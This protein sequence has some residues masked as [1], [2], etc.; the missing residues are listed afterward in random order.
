MI[1]LASTGQAYAAS[2]NYLKI[3][4]T[5]SAGT[6]SLSPS[7]GSGTYGMNMQCSIPGLPASS[8][9]TNQNGG[10]PVSTFPT[11]TD[12]STTGNNSFQLSIISTPPPAG[13]LLHL[14][15]MMQ[16]ATPFSGD[17]YVAGVPS[18]ITIKSL[19]DDTNQTITSGGAAITLTGGVVGS[20]W[21][22]PALLLPDKSLIAMSPS[23]AIVP[24][25]NW[26]S[27]SGGN[28]ISPGQWM[29]PP[30]Q[31]TYATQACTSGGGWMWYRREASVSNKPIT[32]TPY[33]VTGQQT[34]GG[35]LYGL[36]VSGVAGYLTGLKYGI[37]SSGGVNLAGMVS[38]VMGY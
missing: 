17:Y 36:T 14:Y 26:F 15:D 5:P 28:G 11:A 29:G 10:N 2:I 24:A 21:V 32:L 8:F 18:T 3:T 27:D 22:T 12:V 1:G 35:N 4:A 6:Y 7:P 34:S 9:W 25:L 31:N 30:Y 13:R 23:L 16:I 20:T 19:I 33:F 38:H 37:T